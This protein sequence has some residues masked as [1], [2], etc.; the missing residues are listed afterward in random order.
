MSH[1]SRL[2]EEALLELKKL[3]DMHPMLRVS[4]PVPTA[5]YDA[6]RNKI[7]R[8][9]ILANG[10]TWDLLLKRYPTDSRGLQLLVKVRGLVK[11]LQR[12]DFP[13]QGLDSI[14][15]TCLYSLDNSIESKHFK[16]LT[17]DDVLCLTQ[18]L[19]TLRREGFEAFILEKINRW[20]WEW[21]TELAER[22]K[23]EL[24]VR[25]LLAD[26]AL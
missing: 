25:I 20:H 16:T 3:F 9:E 18:V 12:D 15:Y 21:A 22:S 7:D 19:Q 14:I 23:E 26:N 11:G 13:T 4:G 10:V 17:L 6:L 2:V 5:Y 24:E 8:L 1:D